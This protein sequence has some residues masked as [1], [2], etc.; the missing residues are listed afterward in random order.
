MEKGPDNQELWWNQKI[1]VAKGLP[2]EGKPAPCCQGFAHD[3]DSAP[4]SWYPPNSPRK[5][6]SPF[7]AGT[8]LS[9][10]DAALGLLR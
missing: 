1:Q 2:W 5:E 6:V 10:G 9:T 8:G 7:S 4:R 3:A